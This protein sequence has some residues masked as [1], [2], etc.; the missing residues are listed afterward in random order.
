MEEQPGGLRKVSAAAKELGAMVVFEG[1]GGLI[2][3]TAVSVLKEGGPNSVTKAAL[4]ATVAL[5]FGL[6]ATDPWV[7]FRENIRRQ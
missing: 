2:G 1:M 4:G 6:A 7:K 3:G 5:G